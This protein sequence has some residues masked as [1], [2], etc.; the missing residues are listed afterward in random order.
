[1]DKAA[2]LIGLKAPKMPEIPDSPTVRS[3]LDDQQSRLAALKGRQRRANM[4]GRQSLISGSQAGISRNLG[5]D[6]A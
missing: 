3:S 6:G 2:S 4:M 5:G 1:M